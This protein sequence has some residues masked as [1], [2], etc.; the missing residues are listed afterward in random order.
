MKCPVCRA[1][2]RPSPACLCKR[3][4]ADLTPLVAIHDRAIHHYR[5]AIERFNRGD[6]DTAQTH[7][8][9]A[10]VIDHNNADFYALSGQIWA[11]QGEFQRAIDVWK[12]AKQLDPKHPIAANCLQL[13]AELKNEN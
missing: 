3:C 10:L 7:L 6:Y 11:L 1:P 12:Q 9:Q 8:D 5:Q 2:Y 13:M 4:G